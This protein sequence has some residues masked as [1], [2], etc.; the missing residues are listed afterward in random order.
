MGL[1]WKRKGGDQFVSLR[2]NEPA[3]AE[4][5][6]EERKEEPQASARAGRSVESPPAAAAVLEP[7]ATAGGPTPIPYER[8]EQKPASTIARPE[9]VERSVENRQA[10]ISQKPVPSRSP[11]ATSVLGLNLSIEELQ[12]QEA[13]LE[14]NFLRAFAALWLLPANR[15]PIGLTRFSRD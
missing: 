4:S 14:Q 11:F 7:T 9:V 3:Q 13:A 15:F 6:A 8:P 5:K 1:F 10:E 12:A 2:L